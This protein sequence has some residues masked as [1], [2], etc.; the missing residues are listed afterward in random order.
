MSSRLGVLVS[1][2][3][4][5]SQEF[6]KK[7]EEICSICLHSHSFEFREAENVVVVANDSCDVEYR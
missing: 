6:A 5:I 1:C 7:I 2:R 3:F 4:L